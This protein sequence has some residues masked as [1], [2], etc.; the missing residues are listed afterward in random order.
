[1][2]DHFRT[3]FLVRHSSADGLVWNVHH[4]VALTAQ[5]SLRIGMEPALPPNWT[6]SGQDH[7]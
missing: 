3:G 6:Y 7:P 1:M 5:L 4:G 2:K